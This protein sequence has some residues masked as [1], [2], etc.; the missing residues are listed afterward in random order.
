MWS[1]CTMECYSGVKGNEK[2]ENLES[3]KIS[4]KNRHKEPYTG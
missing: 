1:I 4:K 2:W 3:I